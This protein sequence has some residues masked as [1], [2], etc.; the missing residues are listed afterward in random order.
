MKLK[1]YLSENGLTLYTALDYE[2]PLEAKEMASLTAFLYGERCILDNVISVDASTLGSYIAALYAAK[3]NAFQQLSPIVEGEKIERVLEVEL[4]DDV[5][6]DSQ[7]E[8]SKN[9]FENEIPKLV[10]KVDKS[11]KV[12]SEGS[13]KEVET[14]TKSVGFDKNMSSLKKLDSLTSVIASDVASFLTRGVY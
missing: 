1:D 8:T 7:D 4:E 5:E 12:K 14:I 9:S 2:T 3:W 11:E 10:D 6:T 13:R